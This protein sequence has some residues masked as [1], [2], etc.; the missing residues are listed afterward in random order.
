MYPMKLKNNLEGREG[1]G[2]PHNVTPVPTFN[3]FFEYQPI[4]SEILTL[5]SRY[6]RA[7][8]ICKQA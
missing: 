8:T 6:D 4:A 2:C 3:W 5:Q 7:E 1:T